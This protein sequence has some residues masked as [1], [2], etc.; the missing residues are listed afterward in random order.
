[1]MAARK[2]AM[3]RSAPATCSTASASQKEDT[4]EEKRDENKNER[5]KSYILYITINIYNYN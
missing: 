4:R 2:A 5:R 3:V 1:M